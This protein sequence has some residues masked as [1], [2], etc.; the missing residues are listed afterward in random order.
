VKN[1]LLNNTALDQKT[2]K[3]FI[4]FI[5]S[6]LPKEEEVVQFEAAK[7]MCE[8]FEVFGGKVIDIEV[9]FQVLV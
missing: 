3:N 1:S 6:C 4:T 7:S 2:A 5:E 8:L 9:A